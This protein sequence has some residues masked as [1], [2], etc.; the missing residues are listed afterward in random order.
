MKNSLY[1]VARTHFI[2]VS[3]NFGVSIMFDMARKLFLV[4]SKM[5]AVYSSFHG[6]V[7]KKCK[8]ST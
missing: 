3:T 2:N 7:K 4:K 1:K 8:N 6:N 5:A